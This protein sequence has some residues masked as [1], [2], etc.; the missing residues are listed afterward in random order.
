MGNVYISKTPV[1]FDIAAKV[2]ADRER[3]GSV[4]V[5]TPLRDDA[6]RVMS[7]AVP[8]MQPMNLENIPGE[9]IERTIGREFELRAAAGRSVRS[10]STGV[11]RSRR[12]QSSWGMRPPRPRKPTIAETTVSTRPKRPADCGES[13]LPN[14]GPMAPAGNGNGVQPNSMERSEETE[15]VVQ[16]GG[17]VNWKS[18]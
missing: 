7:V 3:A 1:P 6:L 8:R 5:Y 18:G 9:L 2:C 10:T 11:W 16:H 15:N 4:N 12:S 14:G 13:P 17:C